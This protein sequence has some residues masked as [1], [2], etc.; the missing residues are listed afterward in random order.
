MKRNVCKKWLAATLAATLLLPTLSGCGQDAPTGDTAE[1]MVNTAYAEDMEFVTVSGKTVTA[2]DGILI[3]FPEM[4]FAYLMPEAWG[5]LDYLNMIEV[6]D[7]ACLTF[8]PPSLMPDLYNMTEEEQNN[9]DFEALYDAQIKLSEVFFAASDIPE[10]N[11]TTN[12]DGY[13]K[14][15]K[16]ATLDNITY[17]IAYN[18]TIS[19]EEYPQLTQEDLDAFAGYADDL[20]ELK[21]NI[22][23]FPP[24]EAADDEEG[25]E[26]EGVAA[27]QMQLLQG[28]DMNGNAVDSS[29]FADYDLTMVNIWATWCGPCVEELPDL[30]EL[31]T[32][33]PDN[34]NLITICSDAD[35]EKETAAEFLQECGAEFTTICGDS[36]IESNILQD[37]TAF[38]TTIFVDRDGKTVGEAVLGS[39]SAEDY[40]SEITDRL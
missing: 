39:R 26:G 25:S 31:Y 29:I 16:L 15:E 3:P 18:E 28:V 5:Y 1:G 35:I 9:F 20:Q 32:M 37:I 13:Q 40:L 38:P 19:S 27:E 22:I 8:I 34:V 2:E 10:T 11:A 7:G 36:Y 33:L 17:Y 24:Q 23:I 6:E 4:G 14:I 21:D 30:A 12:E